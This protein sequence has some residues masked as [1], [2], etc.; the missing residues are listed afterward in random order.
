MIPLDKP[1]KDPEHCRPK[2]SIPLISVMAKTLEGVV[3]HRTI[4]ALEQHI[5]PGQY[6]YCR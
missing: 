3:L 2:R 6:A 5:D 1:K 4:G